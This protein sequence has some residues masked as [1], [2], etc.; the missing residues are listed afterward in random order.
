M[1]NLIKNIICKFEKIP[2]PKKINNLWLT[3][4]RI[5]KDKE[6]KNINTLPYTLP[7]NVGTLIP[8]FKDNKAIYWYKVIK[9]KSLSNSCF[10]DRLSWDDGNNYDLIYH[11]KEYNI[12]NLNDKVLAIN[13][14]NEIKDLLE[15]SLERLADIAPYVDR[16][17]NASQRAL[18]KHI[19]SKVEFLMI[20]DL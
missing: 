5:R 13:E 9:V 11:H 19:L 15:K 3:Y 12:I 17:Q 7:V 20:E 16:E 6:Y 14:L 18:H 8:L 1:K 10:Q 4:E 2:Y